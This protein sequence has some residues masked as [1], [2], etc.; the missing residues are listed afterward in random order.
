MFNPFL[1]HVR[2]YFDNDPSVVLHVGLYADFARRVFLHVRLPFWSRSIRFLLTFD[3][4]QHL[5][6]DS[7]LPPPTGC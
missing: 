6:F 1:F 3:W 7:F 2:L 5:R 4:F